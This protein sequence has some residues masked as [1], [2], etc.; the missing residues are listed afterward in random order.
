MNVATSKPGA[1][2][3]QEKFAILATYFL[4]IEG[5]GFEVLFQDDFIIVR[6]SG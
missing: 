1:A 2:K 6:Q 4:N 3:S 5:E